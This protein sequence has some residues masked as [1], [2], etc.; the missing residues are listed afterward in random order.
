MREPTIFKALCGCAMISAVALATVWGAGIPIEEKLLAS[1]RDQYVGKC[2]RYDSDLVTSGYA[3]VD[4]F[5]GRDFYTVGKWQ[6]ATV[7]MTSQNRGD[8]DTIIFTSVGDILE[9][10]PSDCPKLARAA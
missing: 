2:V 10:R 9:E 5:G 7:K 8:H 3:R 1:A 6:E 4:L